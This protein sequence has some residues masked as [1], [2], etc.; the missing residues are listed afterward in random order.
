M[1]DALADLKWPGLSC[2]PAAMAKACF[3]L[4]KGGEEGGRA[5]PNPR[6]IAARSGGRDREHRWRQGNRGGEVVPTEVLRSAYVQ[7]GNVWSKKGNQLLGVVQK[8]AVAGTWI[9]IDDTATSNISWPVSGRK[10]G[11][12]LRKWYGVKFS[13]RSP[14]SSQWWCCC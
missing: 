10:V 14:V 2:R 8:A 4:G 12:G 6:E 5:W 9:K 11:G 1:G 7:D 3:L 13:G